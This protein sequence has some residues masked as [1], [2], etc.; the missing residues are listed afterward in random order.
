ME[1]LQELNNREIAGLFWIALLI[2][3]TLRK[4][5]AEH[6]RSLFEAFTHPKILQ[7]YGAMLAY[8]AALVSALSAMD[9][10]QPHQIK[11]TIL[12]FLTVAFLAP[13]K[14]G[15][16]A[17]D[18]HYFRNEF[19]QHFRVIV[20]VEFIITAYT[21]PLA[22]EMF[23][24]P[25]MAFLGAM[26]AFA[27]SSKDH[28]NLEQPLVR[29]TGIVGMSIILF[30]IYKIATEPHEIAQI[31]SLYDFSTPIFLSIGLLPFLYLFHVFAT[32]ETTLTR[33]NFAVADDLYPYA[34]WKA[35]LHFRLDLKRLEHWANI[36]SRK[37]AQSRSDI[38]SAISEVKRYAQQQKIP[39]LVDPQDGWSPYLATQFLE[40]FKLET[41]PY[42][43]VF[44]DEWSGS[45]SSVQIND[46]FLRNT[47]SYY[48]SGERD[49]VK[50]LTLSLSVMS[51]EAPE[52]TY[53]NFASIAQSLYEQ[54]LHTEIDESIL[55]AVSSEQPFESTVGNKTIKLTHTD[56]PGGKIHD[57]SLIIEVQSAQ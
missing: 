54:S 36:L 57:V 46:G 15:D 39:P 30:T 49:A 13:I 44:E 26:T 41:Q 43:A 34:R 1:L 6:Y 29:L 55:E 3:W 19:R 52:T 27:G 35:V 22:F 12:W 16:I 17:E 48:I 5:G 25:F 2:L 47:V 8:I 10:W 38:D 9:L 23:F 40:A 53:E 24:V 45:S 21:F 18:E 50:K 31:K 32:Y 4:G 56:W 11:G 20:V 42:T 14:H 7:T 33:L 51:P 28:K 37:K